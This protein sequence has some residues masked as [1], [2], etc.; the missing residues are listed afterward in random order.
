[1][2]AILIS[3]INIIHK[4]WQCKCIFW[5]QCYHWDCGN[6]M[7]D[8][9]IYIC[10]LYWKL[11]CHM[12]IC[13]IIVNMWQVKPCFGFKV[14]ITAR[15]E[16]IICSTTMHPWIHAASEYNLQLKDSTHPNCHTHNHKP[17]TQLFAFNKA[18]HISMTIWACSQRLAQHVA[19]WACSQMACTTCMSS[20]MASECA[21]LCHHAEVSTHV[22]DMWVCNY[23][24][25]WT[26]AM[27]N[28]CTAG[29]STVIVLV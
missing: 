3:Q 15:D 14:P 22:A 8:C 5:K 18:K 16:W 24:N 29:S 21:M 1:M 26:E 23:F 17:V 6:L 28:K 19:I 7:S 11:K 12:M 25:V 20:L 10:L 13:S 9:I 27:A 2:L 4:G